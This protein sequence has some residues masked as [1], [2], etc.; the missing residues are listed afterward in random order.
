[1]F[2]VLNSV[3]IASHLASVNPFHAVI[4]DQSGLAGVYL[5]MAGDNLILMLMNLWRY[6]KGDWVNRKV[7]V[8]ESP[9][10]PLQPALAGDADAEAVAARG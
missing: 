7:F 6:R 9:A 5:A 2:G 4:V 3:R 10:T 1:M 8:G